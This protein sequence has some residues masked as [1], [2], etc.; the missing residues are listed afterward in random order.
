MTRRLRDGG[1]R[2]VG[3]VGLGQTV[4]EISAVTGESRS[5]DVVAIR[6]CGLLRIS[7][8]DFENLM[9]RHAG[10]MLR[11]A[12]LIIDRLRQDRAHTER[13]ALVSA[14]TYAL[15]PG[16]AGIDIRR[17]A[18]AF[19]R[20]LA[21]HGSTLR[22]DPSR[23]DSALGEDM[24]QTRFDQVE[25]NRLISRWLNNLE[26]RYRY[27][28]YQAGPEPDA[29]TRRCLRQ[30]DRILVV[31]D[32]SR[33]VQ[34]GSSLKWWR[35]NDIR[36]PVEVVLLRD[37]ELPASHALAWRREC[38]GVFHH[39]VAAG[40]PEEDMGRL[41]RLVAGRANCLV[42]G[43]GGARGF[44]HLGL[45]RAMLEKGVPIDM[46]AGTSMGALIGAMVASRLDFDRMLE[47]LRETFVDTNYLNDYVV[48]RVSLIRGQK[49]RKRLREIFGTVQIEDLPVPFYCVSTNIT[50]GMPMIHDRGRLTHWVGTSMAVP[51]IAPPTVY[52]GDLLMDGGLMHSVPFDSML[53]HGRGQVMVSDVSA[54]SELRVDVWADKDEAE[55]LVNVPEA[56]S[57]INIFKIL[58]HTATLTSERASR[59]ID[60]RADFVVRMPVERIGMFDWEQLDSIVYRAYHHA[61]E[62]LDRDLDRML[63]TESLPWEWRASA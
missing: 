34:L 49:F 23:V 13:E 31:A 8:D 24:A 61:H 21:R 45:I 10:A 18:V 42:F 29:W 41:A 6:D 56:P 44:A 5:T 48:P 51:G 55:S 40:L 30:A 54:E 19:G 2:L 7:K 32:A 15:V 16:H 1:E 17:F 12:R 9:Q 57:H 25:H 38:G 22:L 20:T 14:R 26:D 37:G 63:E 27:L 39:H 33:E 46:V 62:V 60:E 43:G 53:A 3:E 28:V 11:V 4:G 59:E 50:R 58:F 47:V 35:A 52:R 36:A